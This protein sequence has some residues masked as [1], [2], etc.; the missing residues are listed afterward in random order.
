MMK[1]KKINIIL[2]LVSFVFAIALLITNNYYLRKYEY[3]HNVVINNIINNIKNKDPDIE[4]KEIIDILNDKNLDDND[5]LLTYGIDITKSSISLSGEHIKSS[6]FVMNIVLL[7]SFSI[8]I[9]FIVYF[10]NKK[11]DNEIKKLTHYLEEIN[12][13]NYK[14]DILSNKE[15]D[16]SIL[17]NEIYK[18]MVMLRESAENSYSDK[19]SIKNSLSDISHQLKTPL[20]SIS[21]M[22]DNII[23]DEGM[24]DEIRRE[25]ILDIKREITNINFLVLNIL[26]LSKFDTNTVTFNKDNIN[27]FKLLQDVKKN[28]DVISDLKDVIIKIKCDK[29]INVVGDYKWEVEAITNIVKNSIE[30]SKD[31]GEVDIEV[32]ENNAFTIITIKDYGIGINPKNLKH[33]FER[34]YKVSESDTGFGIGLS[35]AKMIIETDNGSINVKSKEN[36]GTTFE[37]K[38]KKY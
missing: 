3:N 15:D 27:I 32:M 18:T 38:Y 16:I 1:N 7:I 28:V 34:F 31:K 37:I 24:S 30:H 29:S 5:F 4:D 12:R 19:V 17:Q 23:D 35:L 25:F 21:I 11:K 14:L 33:I 8:L 10:F 9:L 20:T 36:D 6:L 13:K 26:K 2:I 22:L